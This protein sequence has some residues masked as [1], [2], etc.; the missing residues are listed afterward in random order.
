MSKLIFPKDF[1]WGAAMAAEQAEGKGT[2]KKGRTKWDLHFE[3]NPEDFFDGVG[4]ELTSDF[5]RHYKEDIKQWKEVAGINSIRL[6]FSWVRLFPDGKTLNKEA[7]KVY[8]DILDELK[9]CEIKVVMTLFHFDMPEWAIIKGGWADMNTVN[10]YVDYCNF[11]FE[12]YDSKVDMFAT[13]NEPA[14]PIFA[15]YLETYHWPKTYDPQLAFNAGNRMILA[16]ARVVNLFNSKKRSAKIGVVINVSPTHPKDKNNAEDV[17]AAAKFHLIHNLWMLDPMLNGEFPEGLKEAFAELGAK[18]FILTD[19][20]VK[21]V[22][23]VKLDFVGTNY[24]MPSRFKKYEGEE[25]RTDLEK[26]ATPWQDPKARMNVHRGWEIFPEDIYNTAMLIKNRYHNLPF[27]ISENG[28]GVQNEERFRGSNGEIDDQYRIAF[29]KEHLEWCHKAIQEGANLFGYHMW[30]IMDNWSWGN[31]YKN[32]YGFFEVDLKT[33][34]R[35]PKASAHWYKKAIDENGFDSN[36][37]KLDE[38]EN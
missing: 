32:R 26:F 7:V 5:L 15:G 35:K 29:V 9:K 21:E 37:T 6:G 24:Y 3:K 27:F 11:I 36:Y 28:M 1:M 12:E 23:K 25:V 2:T 14:V 10:K 19:D 8:H 13:M 33:Q 38:L 16:H 18:E 4:P 17:K 34:E 22:S 31:A 30:A 20:E